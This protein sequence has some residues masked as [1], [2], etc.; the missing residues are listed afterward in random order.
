MRRPDS[1]GGALRSPLVV[2]GCLA[3]E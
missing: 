1:E 2:I 3:A